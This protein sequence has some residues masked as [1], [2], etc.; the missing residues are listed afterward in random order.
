MRT[1]RVSAAP[2]L[3]ALIARTAMG[4]RAAFADLY[5]RTCGP[6]LGVV[7]R[8]QRDRALAEDIL[9]E[10]FVNVWRAA[11]GFDARSG[12]AMTWLVSIARHRAIDGLRRAQTQPRFESSTRGGDGPDDDHD[13]YDDVATETPEPGEWLG[14]ADEAQAVQ[15]C[16]AGLSGEQQQSIA[17]AFYQ[18][19]SHAELAAHLRQPLGTV[20]SWVRR[21]LMSLKACLERCGI[22]QGA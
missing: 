11:R 3:D 13:L 4:D 5:Q 7:L 20:K 19:L 9:Q 2:E 18:G 10:V 21:G 6:L 17:L 8:I 1:T 15:R 16:L 14:Q 22:A 12:Q